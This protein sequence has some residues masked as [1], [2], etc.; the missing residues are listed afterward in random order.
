MNS[1]CTHR[2]KP[3]VTINTYSINNPVSYSYRLQMVTLEVVAGK[4]Q[5]LNWI[6]VQCMHIHVRYRNS[7][8]TKHYDKIKS[9]KGTK[10]AIIAA[11]RKMM[12]AIYVMLKEDRYFRPDG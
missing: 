11:A 8:I 1:Y 10:I 3:L 6:I 9:R 5:M 2:F 12:R 4:Y 7:S